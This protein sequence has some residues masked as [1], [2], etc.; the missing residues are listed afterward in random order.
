MP[1]T[2]AAERIGELL[3]EG[4]LQIVCNFLNCFP[5]GKLVD[6]VH[7]AAVLISGETE[8]LIEYLLRDGHRKRNGRFKTTH[9]FV[10]KRYLLALGREKGELLARSRLLVQ[11]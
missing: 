2:E 6:N 11:L 8:E 9:S 1:W 10:N 7:P 3:N 5:F 4:A